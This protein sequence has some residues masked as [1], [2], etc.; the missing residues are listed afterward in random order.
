MNKNENLVIV[1][2]E[3][4]FKKL[5]HKLTPKNGEKTD[6]NGVI[7]HINNCRKLSPKST[8]KGHTPLGNL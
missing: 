4:Q 3:P 5:I 1:L 7:Q 8:S 6:T 2:R